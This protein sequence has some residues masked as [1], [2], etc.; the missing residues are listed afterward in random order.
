M[1]IAA[2]AR[3]VQ[4]RDPDRCLAV[5]SSPLKQREKLF[6]LLAFNLEIARTPWVSA[7]P[8]IA[9]M[10]LQWWLDTLDDIYKGAPPRAHEVAQP[11][12]TLINAT[13]PP[14][15]LFCDLIQ[16]RFWDIQAQPHKDFNAM[17]DY[18]KYTSGYMMG[19]CAAVLG[20]DAQ[21]MDAIID[22]GTAVG[23]AH[24][25]LAVPALLNAQ[26]Q[27]LIDMPL[28]ALARKALRKMGQARARIGK[29][30]PY[31][32]ALRLG[33]L[34]RPVL[35]RAIAHPE[36]VL[37]GNLRPSQFTLKSRLLLSTLSGRY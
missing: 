7:E 36:R 25:L 4:R 32:G 8:M 31:I 34:A 6:I 2:C 21:D 30:V 5:M 27:P 19:L 13:N 17:Q 33:Y 1:S 20:A 12:T 3:L 29:T 10:R 15:A 9:Q 14:Q 22:Y 18:I 26:K 16:A 11:L 35:K 37:N 28:D 24:Y 23:W